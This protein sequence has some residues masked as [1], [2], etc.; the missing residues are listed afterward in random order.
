MKSNTY[1]DLVVWQK[2]C[3]LSVLIYKL[4][5]HLPKHEQFGLISQMQRSAVSIASNIAEGS[6]RGSKKDFVHFLNIANGSSAE[7]Q[8][9][10]YILKK[11]KYADSLDF[12]EITSIQEEINK[13]LHKLI[14]ALK[15]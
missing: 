8:T 13:M 15:V 6:K 7:L 10:I 1:E 9:Q 12:S 5:E 11:L 14:L 3:D 4:C 2:S